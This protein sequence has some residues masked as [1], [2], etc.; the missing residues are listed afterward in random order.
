M[1]DYQQ[2]QPGTAINCEFP[3][4]YDGRN[5]AATSYDFNLQTPHDRISN[6]AVGGSNPSGRTSVTNGVSSG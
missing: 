2:L 6:P 1:S 5:D 4:D 3:V